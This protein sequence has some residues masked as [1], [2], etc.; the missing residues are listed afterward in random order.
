MRPDDRKN[1]SVC[2]LCIGVGVNGM[3][4]D[5]CGLRGVQRRSGGFCI[6]Q[7]LCGVCMRS[8]GGK[9][10]R[11]DLRV[12]T[13]GVSIYGMRSDGCANFCIRALGVR[14]DRVRS[15]GGN[16]YCTDLS[17]RALSIRVDGV[18]SDSGHRLGV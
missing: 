1:F 18:R 5:G 17:V 10:Q 6:G 11:H 7:D 16:G 8:D 4:S 14:V 15:N 3:R 13:L 2:T 9:R 12:G